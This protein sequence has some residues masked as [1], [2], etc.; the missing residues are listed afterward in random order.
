MCYKDI[1]LLG[2]LVSVSVRVVDSIGRSCKCKCKCR[3]KWNGKSPTNNRCNKRNINNQN[4][5]KFCV[6]SE[7]I[8]IG[9]V[10]C[11]V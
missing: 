2:K 5:R 7:I 10:R 4:L 9:K 8:E 3:C 1:R 11:K 6:K